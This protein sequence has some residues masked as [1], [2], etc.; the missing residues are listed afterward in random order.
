[1]AQVAAAM[2]VL[3]LVQTRKLTQLKDQR[4]QAAAVV[5]LVGVQVSLEQMAVLVS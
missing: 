5:A 4:T 1:V 2:V 3:E